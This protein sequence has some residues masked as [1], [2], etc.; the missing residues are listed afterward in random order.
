[1][2]SHIRTGGTL[3]RGG[4]ALRP[5]RG[6]AR[7]NAGPRGGGTPT[8]PRERQEER[9]A[10]G[11]GHSDRAEG[12]PGGTL[13]RGGGALRPGRGNARR[14]AGPRGGGTPT[15]PRERQEERWS[16]GG[17]HSDRA[18]GTPGGTLG[19]G[20][21]ALRPGRGNARRNAGP[22]GEGTPTGPR[23]RQEER[24]AEGGYWAVMGAPTGL[25]CVFSNGCLGDLD[26][27]YDTRLSGHLV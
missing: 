22:R 14:N 12:T 7:R 26:T 5:G 1:M 21:G 23:E 25:G 4:G 10:E 24:W 20:G 8:G 16:E 3:G 15:G 13:G 17:G 6:N 27:W 18:E 19:R 11:G 2:R 9:W